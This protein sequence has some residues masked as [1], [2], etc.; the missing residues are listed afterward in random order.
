[1]RSRSRSK[2]QAQPASAAA[3]CAHEIAYAVACV[4]GD[5]NR[6]HH[7]LICRVCGMVQATSYEPVAWSEW[8]TPAWS[9]MADGTHL[10]ILTG[11]SSDLTALRKTCERA[12]LNERLAYL[13]R[14]CE[15]VK[16]IT[17]AAAHKNIEADYQRHQV[18][19]RALFAAVEVAR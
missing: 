17:P 19:A 6:Y 11:P 15:A 7:P 2:V 3:P 8:L 18:H 5:G 12:A 4:T 13:S 1:M 9:N 16:A 10:E 14:E